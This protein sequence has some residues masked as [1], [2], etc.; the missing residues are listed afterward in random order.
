MTGDAIAVDA[1]TQGFGIRRAI[2]IGSGLMLVVMMTEVLCCRSG[3]VLAIAG[4]RRPG[5]L[6]R[7]KY[8]KKDRE[9]AA[10]GRDCISES[11]YRKSTAGCARRYPPPADM[12][13]MSANT[14]IHMGALPKFPHHQQT[15]AHVGEHCHP[16]GCIA[17]T[18]P[19]ALSGIGAIRPSRGATT[20][21]LWARYIP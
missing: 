2:L 13:P 10:H 7:Q 17:K 6:E 15:R 18:P 9:P 14:A 4:H 8:E 3:L 16:H 19:T 5:E 11:L 20:H 12:A 1:T 21:P